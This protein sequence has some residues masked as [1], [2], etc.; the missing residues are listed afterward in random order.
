MIKLRRITPS[1][2]KHD[3]NCVAQNLIKAFNTTTLAADIKKMEQ[4]VDIIIIMDIIQY[5]TFAYFTDV[6]DI[7]N[8]TKTMNSEIMPRQ[9]TFNYSRIK[10]LK[11][12]LEMANA[13]HIAAKVIVQLDDCLDVVLSPYDI[14]NVAC[15]TSFLYIECLLDNI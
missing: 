13:Y 14:Y 12:R 1:L 3:I 5:I 9:A 15:T 7:S 10:Y 11:K 8:L 2:T 4:G 6:L